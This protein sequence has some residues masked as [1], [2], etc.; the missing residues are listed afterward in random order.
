MERS[1]DRCTY[2]RTCIDWP[3]HFVGLCASN[4]HV[5][6]EVFGSCTMHKQTQT[7]NDDGRL[8]CLKKRFFLVSQ[9]YFS[10]TS[11]LVSLSDS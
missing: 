11:S 4:S 2:V 1:T 5:E 8:S 9:F 6:T 7:A 10:E 3:N